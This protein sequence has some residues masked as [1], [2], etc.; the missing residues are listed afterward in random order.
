MRF[1]S[2]FSLTFLSCAV[3]CGSF[4]EAARG[5]TRT[6]VGPPPL[7]SPAPSAAPSPAPSVTPEHT[8]DTVS[9]ANGSAIDAFRNMI[10]ARACVTI[11]ALSQAVLD[12]PTIAKKM[13][14]LAAD[15]KYNEC[16]KKTH[17]D[18]PTRAK[19]NS[20]RFIRKCAAKRNTTLEG[21]TMLQDFAQAF[22]NGCEEG[23][24]TVFNTEPEV[25][26][27]T[28]FANT[29]SPIYNDF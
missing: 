8:R 1:V 27:E 24:L 2:R 20:G 28:G 12:Y 9:H 16:F 14:E 5:E 3:M 26:P 17:G 21:C 13:C 15:T 18:P 7:T 25:D 6:P 29:T 10:D 4:A 11:T 23:I 22:I 19:F